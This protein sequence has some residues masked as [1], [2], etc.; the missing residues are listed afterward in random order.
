[1]NF[2]RADPHCVI[3]RDVLIR[4]L[5][6]E[7]LR[8]ENMSGELNMALFGTRDLGQNFE[9]KFTVVE[10][11]NGGDRGLLCITGVQL[12][13]VLRGSAACSSSIGVATS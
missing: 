7:E 2:W 5:F 4:S 13:R 10:G 3:T 12:M 6:E 9:L 8:Q 1:M 11:Y